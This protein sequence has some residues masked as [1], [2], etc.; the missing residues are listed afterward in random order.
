MSL[1]PAEREAVC[2]R[3]LVDWFSVHAHALA[4]RARLTACVSDPVRRWVERLVP[5]CRAATVPNGVSLERIRPSRED[6]GGV[7]VV[8]VG[9][10]KPWH[11]VDDLLRAAA[12]ARAP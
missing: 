12:M 2:G 5:G 1:S 11:G 7:V 10:L 3:L 9:T 4:G 8:F 6:P